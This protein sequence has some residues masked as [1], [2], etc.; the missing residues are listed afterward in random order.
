[1]HHRHKSG[2]PKLFVR[3]DAFP[4]PRG[5]DIKDDPMEFVDRRGLNHFDEEV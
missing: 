2:D 1:M 4:E 5:V 3:M